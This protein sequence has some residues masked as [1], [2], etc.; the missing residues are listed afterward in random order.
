ME[1]IVNEIY[2]IMRVT[3]FIIKIQHN[4]LECFYGSILVNYL[5]ARDVTLLSFLE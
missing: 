2:L 1:N 4:K 3:F 5:I